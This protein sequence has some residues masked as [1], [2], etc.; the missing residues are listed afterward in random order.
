MLIHVCYHLKSTS[1]STL[2]SIILFLTLIKF[3]LQILSSNLSCNS[4]IFASTF[5]F[6]DC[7]LCRSSTCY[8]CRVGHVSSWALCVAAGYCISCISIHFRIYFHWSRFPWLAWCKSSAKN[9]ILWNRLFNLNDNIYQCRNTVIKPIASKCNKINIWLYIS[10][11]A[12]FRSLCFLH[13]QSHGI[14]LVIAAREQQYWHCLT[15]NWFLSS[16]YR[17]A[18]QSFGPCTCK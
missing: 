17:H 5:C 18:E 1:I 16:L 2:N 9:T 7:S 11:N 4:V 12:T 14:A 15:S 3:N 8:Q 10:L 13:K 6:C